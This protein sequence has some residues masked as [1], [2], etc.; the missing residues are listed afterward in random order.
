MRGI[1]ALV[2][3]FCC[4]LGAGSAF[5]SDPDAGRG[6]WR[7]GHADGFFFT[8]PFLDALVALGPGGGAPVP[9]GVPFRAHPASAAGSGLWG[10]ALPLASL[11][12]VPGLTHQARV[13]YVRGA[14]NGGIAGFAPGPDA[15]PDRNLPFDAAWGLGLLNFYRVNENLGIALDF[16]YIATEADTQ[17]RSAADNFAAML[18][19]QY[20]F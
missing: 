3:A 20:S 5:A 12:L 9:Q 4:I 16:A 13:A 1:I 15:A 11:S 19:V 7:C 10:R 8:L 6:Q 2:M 18:R 17:N 14:E